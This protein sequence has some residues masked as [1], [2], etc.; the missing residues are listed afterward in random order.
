[1]NIWDSY[2]TTGYLN[3]RATRIAVVRLMLDDPEPMTAKSLTLL[4]PPVV[5]NRPCE[6][7][8]AWPCRIA[9]CSCQPARCIRPER[10]CDGRVYVEQQDQPNVRASLY[11][12][13]RAGIVER[14]PGRPISWSLCWAA[15]KAAFWADVYQE[16]DETTPWSS[17]PELQ[18]ELATKLAEVV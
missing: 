14:G 13:E 12:L 3:G 7:R 17:R 15:E 10:E 16:V 1:M 18:D 6:D 5:M 11:W 9:A 8:A 2:S 4:L